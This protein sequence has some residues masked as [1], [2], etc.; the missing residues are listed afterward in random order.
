MDATLNFRL[1]LR[2]AANNLR[3]H[4]VVTLVTVFG[5]A[6]GMAVIAS[7]LIV[8]ANTAHTRAQQVQVEGDSNPGDRRDGASPGQFRQWLPISTITFER[9][10]GARGGAIRL[11]PT[12]KETVSTDVPAFGGWSD[13]GE[14]DYQA[15]RLAV[16]LASVF[17]FSIGA[18]IVFYTL[19]YSV[20]SR[21]R[22]FSLL[23]CLGE[24]RANVA[25]SLIAQAL[26][27]G[28]AGTA[29]G[30]G[31]AIPASEQLL[32]WGIS[33]NG[34]RP[35]PG[36]AIPWPEL[37]AVA[38]ISVLV[39]ASGVIAPIRRL[40]RLRIAEEL[41][42]RFLVADIS[43]RDFHVRSFGWLVPAVMAAT[44]LAVR[45]LLESWLSVVA[46]F[47][48][49]ATFVVVLSGTILWFA[50]PVLRVVIRAVQATLRPVLPLDSLLAG[51]R[52]RLT[53]RRL[54][55]AVS[56]VTLVFSLLTGL[57]TV[58]R[59]LKDEIFNWGAEALFPYAYFE[60]AS[61][62]DIDEEALQAK[63]RE[64]GLRLFRVSVRVGGE[65]PMRLIR[66]ADVNPYLEE[67][68]R[69]PLTP[70]TTIV[71]RTLAARF[72]LA[73]GDTVVIRSGNAEYRFD[74]LEVADDVG[75]MSE[76]GQ[77]VDIKSYA[78]FSEGNPLFAG[79]LE[80][81]LGQYAMARTVGRTRLINQDQRDALSPFY[82]STRYGIGQGIWQLREIDRD[83]LVFDFI[84]FMTVGLAAIGVANTML[85]Q[86]HAR[87]REF[88]VLRTVGMRRRQIARL[89]VLEGTVVGVVGAMLAA[90][91][92]N[93]LGA[94]SVEFLDAYTLF[95]YQFRFSWQSTAQITVLAIV[96]C[97]VA[98][99]Y[100]AF[101][102]TR[103][104]SAES[105]HYE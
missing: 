24:T 47:A 85:I 40:Y 6:I 70:G 36:H 34:R 42:P 73:A 26:V 25:A 72:D 30:I 10:S 15:M 74:V 41:H 62:F 80:R 44:W 39:A 20:A 84:L 17:T 76:D 52:M 60:R 58:T 67:R 55:F 100:P 64:A 49:E 78:L 53:S 5:V 29:V 75:Y 88:S 32:N 91:L 61:L 45:P 69:L 14:A 57:H 89:L 1:A 63:L 50:T 28:A 65:F 31:L 43:E 18:V 105:L 66:A 33:T 27:L 23:R 11:L 90:V 38:T 68:N 101:V 54:V 93:A 92:G 96:T 12:Q 56:G 79:V 21:G 94:V 22:E 4:M 59:S 46:F 77:Y 83:F 104:S 81:T 9:R 99:A 16:R 102:A 3:H 2:L 19:Q 48:I 95:D 97:A 82:I 7:I 103:I 8:D 13:R 37:V 98:A 51:R 35:L 71:S 87:R 86:I